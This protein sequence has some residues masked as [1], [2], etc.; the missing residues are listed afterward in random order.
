[1]PIAIQIP[2]ADGAGPIYTGSF[3]NKTGN[4]DGNGHAFFI[5][6]GQTGHTATVYTGDGNG[7]FTAQPPLT[8]INGVY[9]MLLQDMDGRSAN[10]TW[11][12]KAQTAP[13]RFTRATATA[14]SLR[15]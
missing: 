14:S 4:F 11:W 7:G 8:F 12:W 10:R 2:S 1:M 5:I 6:N 13:S 3:D 9:S 15:I